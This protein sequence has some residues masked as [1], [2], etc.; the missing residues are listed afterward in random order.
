MANLRHPSAISR[1]AAIGYGAAAL[2]GAHAAPSWARSQARN[3]FTLGVASGDPVPDGFVIWTRLAPDPVAPDGLGGMTG[4]AAVRWEVASDDAMRHVVANGETTTDAV[5]A[6]SVHVEVANLQPNRPYWYRFAA[7]G[8]QSAVGRARTAPRPGQAIDRLQFNFASCS[9]WEQG[10]FSAYRHMADEAPDFT[11]FLGD[12]IYE[13]TNEGPKAVDLVRRHGAPDAVDLPG[14]RNRYALYRTDPDLQALHAVTPALMTWDDHE[15]ENDY[16]DQWSE[17]PYTPPDAFLRRRAAAYRAFYEHMPLRPMSLPHGPDMRVY[18]RFR[19]GDLLEMPILDGRQYR[20]KQPCEL[21]QWRGGHVA[22]PSCTERDDP[23]HTMLGFEQ[24]RWLI[25]GFKR[26][27]ARWNIVAQDVIVASLIQTGKDGTVGHWT[28]AWDGF[29]ACRTRVLDA[30]K[31]SAIK[32]PV[33]IG[34]DIH[35]FWTNDLKAD[36]AD[37]ASETIATEFVG[38]SITANAPPYESF[39]RDLP[40]NP[41][42]KFFD[43]RVHGF[44]SVDLTP[45]RMKTRFQAISERRDP[46]ASVSTLKTFVVETGKTGAMEA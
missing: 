44:V 13:Y 16:A 32:N 45:E 3:P 22:P 25:E 42:V 18:D 20:S 4:A 38:G 9:N 31:G 28:D 24:E 10:Y 23:S 8:E 12:Y 21:P 15:V 39:A 27:N 34:G 6:H 41:Q 40:K 5:F 30:V 19:F 43:S 7:M 17:N 36:F 29:P 11:V 1:R 26:S 33:F 35:S 46:K 2:I 14:Y 37:P